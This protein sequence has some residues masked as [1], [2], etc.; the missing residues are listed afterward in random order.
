MTIATNHAAGVARNTAAST[1]RD[2]AT[3]ATA[4]ERG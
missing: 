2:V 4:G 3:T 1:A